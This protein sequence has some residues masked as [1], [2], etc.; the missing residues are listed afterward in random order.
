M[1][2]PELKVSTG[3]TAPDGSGAALSAQELLAQGDAEIA[4]A[5]R[6]ARGFEAAVN[7]ILGS[8]E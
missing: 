2:N 7:C 4:Q 8:G 3:E 5:K 6:D 1:A